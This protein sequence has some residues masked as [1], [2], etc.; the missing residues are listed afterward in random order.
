MRTSRG[1]VDRRLL[2]PACVVFVLG[3][4]FSCSGDEDFPAAE[5]NGGPGS[6]NPKLP[7]RRDAS[8]DDDAST[9]DAFV[10]SDDA[11]D[12][13]AGVQEEPPPPGRCR[14]KSDC[15]EDEACVVFTGTCNHPDN[16]ECVEDE[17]CADSGVDFIC[18]PPA[19]GCGRACLP[20]CSATS[21]CED[22]FE[23]VAHRCVGKKCTDDDDCTAPNTACIYGTSAPF[24]AKKTCTYDRDCEGGAHCVVAARAIFGECRFDWGTCQ[25][26]TYN[27]D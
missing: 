15:A 26:P 20:G 7:G 16:D 2:A 9:A 19:K 1:T 5:M 6:S 27:F 21:D 12:E 13:D 11:S 4:M 10:P 17:E 3:A 8:G 24:C 23:C 18:D 14:L 22:S 25:V